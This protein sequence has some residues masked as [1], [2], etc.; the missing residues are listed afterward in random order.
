MQANTLSFK[1]K[2]NTLRQTLSTSFETLMGNKKVGYEDM[3]A[4]TSDCTFL[5]AVKAVPRTCLPGWPVT[6]PRGMAQH[7]PS[8]ESDHIRPSR[9]RMLV[10]EKAQSCTV[11]CRMLCPIIMIMLLLLAQASEASM[12]QDDARKEDK[13][14][15]DK[16]DTASL[17]RTASPRVPEIDRDFLQKSSW[18][19]RMFKRM[20]SAG[21]LRRLGQINC[22]K[23]ACALISSHITGEIRPVE[24]LDI[25]K[26]DNETVA[27][28]RWRS[29]IKH[30]LVLADLDRKHTSMSRR[31]EVARIKSLNSIRCV[32]RNLFLTRP[33]IT[34]PCSKSIDDDPMVDEWTTFFE[35]LDGGAT[36]DASALV[37]RGGI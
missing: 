22:N 26:R 12:G 7:R 25:E 5:S 1:I 18:Q 16:A 8:K 30:V 14:D 28:A 33:R 23:C 20:T 3:S 6:A 32:L 36:A 9:L 2:F 27:A 10:M 35:Q 24:T 4:S 13:T 11:C 37:L 21:A 19:F 17:A 29:A 31:Q 15:K 34:T